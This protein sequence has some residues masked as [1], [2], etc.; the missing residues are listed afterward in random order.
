MEKYN[1][2]F[3][4]LGIHSTI[5]SFMGPFIH[6]TFLSISAYECCDKKKKNHFAG[7]LRKYMEKWLGPSREDPMQDLTLK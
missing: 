7:D 1:K 3:I 6:S 4:N 5:Y 2:P